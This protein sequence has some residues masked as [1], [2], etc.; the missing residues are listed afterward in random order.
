MVTV[1]HRHGKKCELI[2]SLGLPHDTPLIE[3]HSPTLIPAPEP[4][5]VVPLHDEDGTATTVTLD[6]P[7]FAEPGGLVVITGS[8]YGGSTTVVCADPRVSL[9]AGYGDGTF[10]VWAGYLK[11]TDA[12]AWD[13]PFLV[14][15]TG[16]G[17][18]CTA[19]LSTLDRGIAYG[20]VS[21][22]VNAPTKVAAV[23][24]LPG[25]TGVLVLARA[26]DFVVSGVTITPPAGYTFLGIGD[27][28]KTRTAV[29]Y[30]SGAGGNPA[31]NFTADGDSGALQLCTVEVLS[32][33]ERAPHLYGWTD[34]PDR[35]AALVDYASTHGRT[36]PTVN[37]EALTGR[38]NLARY[39]LDDVP[40]TGERFRLTLNADVAAAL[41]VDDDERP[42]FTGEITDVTNPADG[43]LSVVTVT[44][45]G[46]RARLNRL[47]VTMSRPQETDG[48]RMYRILF[49]ARATLPLDLGTIED[50]S[51]TLLESHTLAVPAS[52][53]VDQVT[54]DSLGQLVEHRSGRLDYQDAD[55]RRGRTSAVTLAG[56]QHLIQPFSWQQNIAAIV[57]DATAL[58]GP[59]SDRRQV[60]LTDPI[61]ANPDTGAGPYPFTFDTQLV[62]QS[63]A[64]ALLTGLVGRYSRPSWWLPSVLVEL[65]RTAGDQLAALV[66]LTHGDQ[67]T[68]E[69]LPPDGAF[70]AGDVFV[71][72]TT[73]THNAH[74]WTLSLAVADPRLAGAGIRWVDVPRFLRWVDVDPDLTWFDVATITDP[75]DLG[76]PVADGGDES[77]ATEVVLIVDGGDSA[78]RGLA[79]DYE[80][81]GTP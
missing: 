30:W 58:Y 60:R 56:D 55:H 33:Q 19:N 20:R 45:L 78:D 8:S 62:A 81:E 49:K 74:G 13:D 52:Q 79:Y 16:G 69:G 10:R 32:D 48:E 61:S 25:A 15:T 43:G 35:T 21:A 67:I 22:V 51:V 5:A 80:L 36:S 6:V 39:F 1:T 24:V 77:E 46:R 3:W 11:G 64:S 40:V 2:A 68:A 41:G 27:R 50:G 54:A 47:P 42:R 37:T 23:P 18:N 17:G 29:F 12:K 57:N 59:E 38:V 75:Y 28:T 72:G 53:L 31:G 44:A 71:E 4:A 76:R 9:I 66:Q 26:W 70:T 7:A 34:N 14:T 73:E 65:Y 63:D